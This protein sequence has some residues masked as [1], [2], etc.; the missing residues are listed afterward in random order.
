[1]NLPLLFLFFRREFHGELVV[2]TDVLLYPFSVWE[3]TMLF[4]AIILIPVTIVR[5]MARAFHVT[6]AS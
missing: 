6:S 5:L 3:I 2:L 4:W 1:M